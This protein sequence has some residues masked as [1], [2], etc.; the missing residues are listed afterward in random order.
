MIIEKYIENK[1]Q[2]ATKSSLNGILNQQ[3]FQGAY[4]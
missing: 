4:K 2:N 1:S 3:Y